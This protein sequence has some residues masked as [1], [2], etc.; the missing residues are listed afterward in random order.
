MIAIAIG[1]PETA[2]PMGRA[3]RD[4]CGPSVIPVPGTRIG[5]TPRDHPG[6]R[7]TGLPVRGRTH[8]G[9]TAGLSVR[10]RR[11]PDAQLRLTAAAMLKIQRGDAR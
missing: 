5:P 2:P 4:G 11:R 7:R 10:P 6:T 9:P 8:A 3:P 1:R